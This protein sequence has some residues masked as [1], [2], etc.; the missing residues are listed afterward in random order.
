[1]N[2]MMTTAVVVMLASSILSADAP[3]FTKKPS[4]AKKG[5]AAI[6]TFAVD[7]ETDVAV[8]VEDANGRIVRHLVAGVLGT[9]APAPLKAG[10]LEQVVEW[11]GK[12]DYGKPLDPRPTTLRFRVALGLGATYDKRL[13]SDPQSIGGIS[14]LVAGPDG[15]VY[16]LHGTGG[17]MSGSEAGAGGTIRAF[18]RDGK[19]LRTVLPFPANLTVEQAKPVAPLLID[20]RPVPMNSLVF[21]GLYPAGGSPRKAGMG[22]TR[23]GVVLR[24][25]CSGY[26]GAVDGRTGAIPWGSYE[27]GRLPGNPGDRACVVVAS[28][29]KSAFVGGLG[30]PVVYRVMLPERRTNAVFFGELAKAGTNDTQLGAA[31]AMGLALDGKG[32]VLISDVSN[33]R[34]IVVNE[35]DGTFAGSLAV[36]APESLGVDPATGAVYVLADGARNLVK[37]ADAKGTKEIARI[38]IEAGGNGTA[39]MTLDA[40]AKPPIVWVGTDGARLIR[41]EDV[42][43]RLTARDINSGSLGGAAFLDLTVDR[44]HPDREIYCKNGGGGSWYWRVS[45]VT[46]KVERV[47]QECAGGGFSGVNIVP[48]PD[49]NLYGLGYP[50]F[51]VKHNRSG[52]ALPWEEPDHRPIPKREGFSGTWPAYLSYFPV[53]MG[54]QP[55]TL[56]VRGSDGHLFAMEPSSPGNRPPKMMREYLPTGKRVSDDPVVW[57]VTDAA[58]GPRFDAAGNIYVADVIRPMD[59]LYPPEFSQVFSNRVVMNQTRPSGAQDAIATS[60]GSIVKFSPKGGAIDYKINT[61]IAGGMVPAPYKGEPKLDPALKTNN[62]SWYACT[63]WHGPEKVIGAEW[64][65]PGISHIGMYYCNCENVTFDVDEF[66]RVFFPDTNLYQVRVIDT[67]GNVLLNFGAYGNMDSCGPESKDKALAVP[68]IA[69]ARLVSVGVTDKYAYCGDS[70]NRRL[71]RVKLAY[72]AE[73]TAAVK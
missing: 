15:T 52:K 11:D 41:I 57:K 27:G 21:G 67:A 61:D 9:N 33:N 72:A 17:T 55:H 42:E 2:R 13:I 5:D 40:A 26:L 60:Y 53:S 34:V 28:D 62:A 20:G 69:F 29:G 25:L 35:K 39:E 56:G 66:G 59:W 46:D 47:V 31:G 43:N 51:M 45:E 68:D 24:M 19:Y 7:R 70:M 18:D 36:K 10:S 12:A 22:I 4:V 8:F 37:F 54:A 65:A 44:F 16:V 6:I 48:A 23:D 58:L 3:K 14:G 64:I 38:K 73:E 49:G 1:M 63:M 50:M 32:H 71:L 30:K